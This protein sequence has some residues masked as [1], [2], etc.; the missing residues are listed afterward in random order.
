M[1][2]MVLLREITNKLFQSKKLEK[3]KSI[4]LKKVMIIYRNNI[5]CV[6]HK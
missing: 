5:L 1:Y 3:D 4:D 2:L 6:T